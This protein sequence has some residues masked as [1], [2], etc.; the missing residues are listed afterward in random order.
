MNRENPVYRTYLEILKRELVCAMGCTEPIALAYCAATAR[1]VLGCLPERILVEASGNIIKNV[2]S[3][4]VP[5]TNGRRGIA[6]AACIGVLGGDEVLGS[7]PP[8]VKTRVLSAFRGVG[9]QHGA[10]LFVGDR[11]L[12]V[13]RIFYTERIKPFIDI[14]R[15]YVRGG[16]DE[17][18]LF[19]VVRGTQQRRE[20]YL[21]HQRH[22]VRVVEHF[23]VWRE[24]REHALGGQLRT[25]R[26]RVCYKRQAALRMYPVLRSFADK[27]G[28]L[29]AQPVPA[30][31]RQPL[32]QRPELLFVDRRFYRFHSDD[33][34][35]S[36]DCRPGKGTDRLSGDL[37]H[38]AFP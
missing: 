3:V 9:A 7:E 15:V 33:L 17:V 11:V 13:G 2:K 10:G 25:F 34:S 16:V 21:P 26:D 35:L 14:L 29:G 20:P 32:S 8:L 28:Y 22:H 30:L 37:P 36:M 18:A 23:R 24:S 31:R 5:N 1:A 12:G 4:V 6:A 19:A 38:D 27:S